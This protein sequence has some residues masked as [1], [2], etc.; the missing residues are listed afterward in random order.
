MYVNNTECG[1]RMV[2]DIQTSTQLITISD[3]LKPV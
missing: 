2:E 1:F 3:K